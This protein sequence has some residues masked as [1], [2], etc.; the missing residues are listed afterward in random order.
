MK[1]SSLARETS[2]S[3]QILLF[4]ENP[5]R[6]KN[7]H[8][9]VATTCKRNKRTSVCA[10]YF[11]TRCE[12]WDTAAAERER[13]ILVAQVLQ[14]VALFP[15]VRHHHHSSLAL[16]WPLNIFKDTKYLWTLLVGLTG[17]N[18]SFL[19]SDG[20]NRVSFTEARNCLRR[21]APKIH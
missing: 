18:T 15:S 19:Q 4:I 5:H 11:T 7:S 17:V 3:S 10:I 2:C 14:H 1:S 6:L 12:R 20:A 13:S 16:G 21:P 8:K 9:P